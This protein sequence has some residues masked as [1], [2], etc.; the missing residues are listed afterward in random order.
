MTNLQGIIGFVYLVL[1]RRNKY[2]HDTPDVL[3]IVTA[4]G[5]VKGISDTQKHAGVKLQS[6]LRLLPCKVTVSRPLQTPPTPPH[7]VAPSFDTIAAVTMIC[8]YRHTVY[9]TATA[10]TKHQSAGTAVDNTDVCK[11]DGVACCSLH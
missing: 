3:N 2:V 1:C 7:E 8:I 9:L 10:A 6:N 11:Q 5:M 4:G